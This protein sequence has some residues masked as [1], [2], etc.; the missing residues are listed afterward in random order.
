[1][2]CSLSPGGLVETATVDDGKAQ[3]AGLQMRFPT[4]CWSRWGEVGIENTVQGRHCL[5]KMHLTVGLGL[6]LERRKNGVL[7]DARL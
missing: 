2:A 4:S 1:M 3:P 6:R 7:G 5:P